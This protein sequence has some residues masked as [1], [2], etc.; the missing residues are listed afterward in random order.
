MSRWRGHIE[1]R[2]LAMLTAVSS[3]AW[4]LPK[5]WK[6]AIVAAVYIAALQVGRRL[7]HVSDKRTKILAVRLMEVEAY[8]T[9]A[10][11][12]ACPDAVVPPFWAVSLSA[13]LVF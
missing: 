3:P 9:K 8:H 12:A 5:V 4:A 6:P 1:L 2:S 7:S 13:R 10:A 11:A